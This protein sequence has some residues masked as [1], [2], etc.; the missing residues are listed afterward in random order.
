MTEATDSTTKKKA[1]VTADQ[2]DDADEDEEIAFAAAAKSAEAA[3]NINSSPKKQTTT[4]TTAATTTTEEKTAATN[5][6]Q[7][8]PAPTLAPV[9]TAPVAPA[10]DSPK[11]AMAATALTL[12]GARPDPPNFLRAA[13]TTSRSLPLLAPSTIAALP[14]PAKRVAAAAPA[15]TN[16]LDALALACGAEAELRGTSASSSVTSASPAPPVAGSRYTAQNGRAYPVPAD[17]ICCTDGMFV[18]L[19]SLLY[20]GITRNLHYLETYHFYLSFFPPCLL[21]KVLCGRG[22]QSNHH[23]SWINVIFIY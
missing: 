11:A 6:T 20:T 18:N 10:A 9:V 5:T 22:G 15:P 3:A 14:A 23:V 17:E 2:F 7:V 16:P 1:P 21:Y 4:S 12:G 8:F 19:D 13:A